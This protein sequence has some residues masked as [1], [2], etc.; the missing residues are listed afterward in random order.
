MRYI[1]VLMLL[2]MLFLMLRLYIIPILFVRAIETDNAGAT[3]TLLDVVPSLL[4]YKPD[5]WNGLSALRLAAG[6]GNANVTRILLIHDA[7]INA[8]EKHLSALH[9]ASLNGHEKV[10]NILLSE[11]ADPNLG[12]SRDGSIALHCVVKGYKFID[13]VERKDVDARN[14]V[15]I[16]LLGLSSNPNFRDKNGDTPLHDAVDALYYDAVKILCE[17]NVNI[18]EVND[19]GET[20]L[21]L[22][23]RKKATHNEDNLEKDADRII[24]FLKLKGAR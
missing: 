2:L 21:K 7:D 12:N 1:I 18:N 10:V 24:E 14:R 3:D 20:P 11:G 23:L 17:A 22:A 15:L 4:V 6:R 9:L 19:R 13:S 5:S 16:L 8:L